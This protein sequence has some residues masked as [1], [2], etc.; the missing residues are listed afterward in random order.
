ML[1]YVLQFT[2]KST[3]GHNNRNLNFIFFDHQA[4]LNIKTKTNASR[5]KLTELSLLLP[6]TNQGPPHLP[7]P[8]PSSPPAA[9]APAATA[10]AA[11]AAA[12]ATPALVLPL[13]SLSLSALVSG[14]LALAFLLSLLLSFLLPLLEPCLPCFLLEMNSIVCFVMNF[15]CN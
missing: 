5:T 11:T 1:T 10:T 12:A 14:L 2:E 9:A 4:I 13:L 8:S 6:L 15:L 3:K 7:L